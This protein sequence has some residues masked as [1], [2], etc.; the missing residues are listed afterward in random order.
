MR[1]PAP[2]LSLERDYWRAGAELV[3]GIDEVGRG[4]WAG[5]LTVAV[6]VIPSDHRIYRIRDSKLL[7]ESQR[8]ELF[9]RVAEWCSDWAV[10]HVEAAECDRLGMSMAQRLAAARA[11]D[12]LAQQPDVVLVDGK[13]DFVNRGETRTIV[14]GDRVSLAIAAASI[15]A[16]VTRDRHMRTI[17]LDLPWYDF[18]HNKGYPSPTHRAALQAWGPSVVHRT[19]WVFMERLA[20]TL[21]GRNPVRS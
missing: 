8:E 18:A 13:W 10:G 17:S 3:A 20:W 12:G 15:L 5:P 11:L 7:S 14:R 6:A 2:T 1:G 16:K 9:A 19:S 4:S 21:D